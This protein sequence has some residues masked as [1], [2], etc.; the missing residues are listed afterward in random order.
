M[1]LWL[2]LITS[3]VN[4]GFDKCQQTSPNLNFT[5]DMKFMYQP[6]Y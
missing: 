5:Y 6:F 3:R 4:S 2:Q 1:S